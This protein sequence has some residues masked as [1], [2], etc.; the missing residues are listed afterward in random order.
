MDD[1]SLDVDLV[2]NLMRE[3]RLSARELGRGLGMSAQGGAAIL[4]GRGHERLTLRDVSRLGRTLGVDPALLL[5][6]RSTDKPVA[7]HDDDVRLE[8]ALIEADRSRVTRAELVDTFGWNLARLRRAVASLEA[9]LVGTAQR[10]DQP[11]TVHLS[12]RGRLDVLT[13][14]ERRRLHRGLYRSR[15]LG[16]NG[17]RVLADAIRTGG[18]DSQA[19][20][21]RSYN[22]QSSFAALVR[23][24]VMVD[25]G[26][27][28]TA[29]PDAVFSLALRD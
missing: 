11:S 2:R 13:E 25:D 8:A 22:E 1:L 4:S 23:C 9:R 17:A 21:N 24:G 7:V 29:H 15:G 18:L 5:V 28:A 27:R 10:L 19:I 26:G 14:D 20:G 16:V 3:R 6:P 12:V